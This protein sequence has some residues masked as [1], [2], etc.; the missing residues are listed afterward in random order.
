MKNHDKIRDKLSIDKDIKWLDSWLE[1]YYQNYYLD[2][3]T[4]FGKT[5]RQQIVEVIISKLSTHTQ[6][7]DNKIDAEIAK[8]REWFKKA[9]DGSEA[10]FMYLSK[11]QA[12]IDI[13]H[14][15]TKDL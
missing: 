7:V 5:P 6:E 8:Y 2:G 1:D 13:K 11:L 10:A 15:L 12:L 9:E 3:N 14:L 4:I